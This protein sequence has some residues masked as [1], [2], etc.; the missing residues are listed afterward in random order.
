MKIKSILF[1]LA[2]LAAGCSSVPEV[3]T[4]QGS[5]V[6]TTTGGDGRKEV[7]ENK[8][9]YAVYVEARLSAMARPLFEM[10]CPATGCVIA[11]LKVGHPGGGGAELSAPVPVQPPAHPVVG[12]MR[13]VKETL[14]GLMPVAMA[15]TT[16][17]YV[18][19]VFD[20]FG[21]TN[22]AMAAQIQAP[23]PNV[24]IGNNSGAALGGGSVSV[25]G[26]V[27][28]TTT[29]NTTTATASGSNSAASTG[30]AAT[31]TNARTCTSGPAG[32]AVPPTT[33]GGSGPV[34][35]Q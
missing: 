9:D 27:T 31:S 17:H 35:C 18:S 6:K 3:A 33:G 8:S 30:G 21:A 34:T 16:G 23:A 20:S 1:M 4:E 29:T 32:T 28:T 12:F 10:T 5:V 24:T 25:A 11:S 13:E 7:L 22:A 15:A 26:P 2:A 14:L 19:K